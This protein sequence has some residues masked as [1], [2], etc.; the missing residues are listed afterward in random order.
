MKFSIYCQCQLRI[1]INLYYFNL[2]CCVFSFLNRKCYFMHLGD[3]KNSM[4]T[5]ISPRFSIL[6]LIRQRANSHQP[7]TFSQ[8]FCGT[9]PVDLLL[10]YLYDRVEGGG[11]ELVVG[12]SCVPSWRAKRSISADTTLPSP[13]PQD[14]KVC[15]HLLSFYE[16]KSSVV[17]LRM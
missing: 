11:G 15:P 3:K 14:F 4:R 16:K 13:R 17:A 2:F 12:V 7:V 8:I 10:C 6:F 1:V 9:Q 5:Q